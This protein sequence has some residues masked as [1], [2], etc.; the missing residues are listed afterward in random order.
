MKDLT[1]LIPCYNE[2]KAL[3]IFMP[4]LLEFCAKEQFHLIFINDGSKDNTKKV[5]AEAIA[6]KEFASL[7]DLKVNRGY[8]GAI[9][10]GI[11]AAKTEYVITIDGDG[12]HLLSDVSNLYSKILSEEADMIIGS[13]KGQASA[14]LFRAVGK[15]LI[16]SFTKLIM[17]LPIYDLNS[18]MK[19]YRRN[20][21]SKYLNFCS[22]GMPFSDS[23]ALMFINEKNYVI[24]I[25]I[26]IKE[27]LAGEST[28]NI[29]T[30]F[31]TILQIIYIYVFYFP[32]KIFITSGLVI[33]LLSIAWGLRF[34]LAGKGVSNGM[35]TGI[36]ISFTMFLLGLIA[37]QIVMVRKDLMLIK[38]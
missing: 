19:I 26:T 7:V 11:L 10:S 13:R 25:P 21:A 4:E 6:G 27:R 20:L 14:S 24:E 9:K 36:L 31:E 15:N 12:Q 18:G 38:G 5:I 33:L 23:I 34:L 3:V 1:I 35:L 8:G 30:A 22:D 2:E 37:Q 28:I 17:H 29:K 16:R 32:L